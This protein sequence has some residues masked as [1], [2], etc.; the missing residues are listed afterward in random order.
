MSRKLVQKLMVG[1]CIF[2]LVCACGRAEHGAS[3]PLAIQLD[4]PEGEASELF[5]YGVQAKVL[6]VLRDGTEIY[7]LDWESGKQVALELEEEDQLRFMAY[8]QN[9]REM[10]RGE[11]VVTKEKKVTIPLH[12]P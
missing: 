6:L 12:R 3:E 1:F 5:W 8:D 2:T 9:G 10:V 11:A 4:L 7:R